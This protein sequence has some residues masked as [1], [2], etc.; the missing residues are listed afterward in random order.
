M[1][2]YRAATGTAAFG[3]D[4]TCMVSG[5]DFELLLGFRMGKKYLQIEQMTI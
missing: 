5:I 4:D 3:R 1:V 2:I